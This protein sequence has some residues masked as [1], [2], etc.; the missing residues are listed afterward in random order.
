MHDESPRANQKLMEHIANGCS[1]KEI[2]ES[3]SI[4]EVTV[5]Q[6]VKMARDKLQATNRAHAVATMFRLGIL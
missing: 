4:S 6:Y 2:V 3:L 1:I 5:K